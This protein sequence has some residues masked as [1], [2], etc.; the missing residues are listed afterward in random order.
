MS[1]SGRPGSSDHGAN[2]R[3]EGRILA[4]TWAAMLVWC[5]ISAGLGSMLVDDRAKGAIVGAVLGLAS[6]GL[7]AVGISLAQG[8]RGIRR[9]D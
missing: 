1:G 2:M 6:T 4:W 7:V 3:R 5:A 8:L 9:R